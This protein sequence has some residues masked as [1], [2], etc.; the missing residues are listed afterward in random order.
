MN[1]HD[2]K[3]IFT[4][5]SKTCLENYGLKVNDGLKLLFDSKAAK[6]RRGI[7]E[8]REVP[9]ATLKDRFYRVSKNYLFVCQYR[10]DTYAPSESV[11]IVITIYKTNRDFITKELVNTKPV[12]AQ[13]Q[14]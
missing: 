13:V 2:Y 7:L 3:I 9:L 6:N 14:N 10:Q 12:P 4:K 11:V 5:H 8:T 1:L